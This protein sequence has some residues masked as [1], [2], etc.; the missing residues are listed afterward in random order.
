M[1]SHVLSRVVFYLFIKLSGPLF[2]YAKRTSEIFACRVRGVFLLPLIFSLHF[3]PR[4]NSIPNLSTV[5]KASL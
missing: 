4:D 3:Y 5:I 2:K 1:I